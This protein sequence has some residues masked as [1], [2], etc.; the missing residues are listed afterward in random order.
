MKKVWSY[1]VQYC[2]RNAL[3]QLMESYQMLDSPE[4]IETSKGVKELIKFLE[5]ENTGGLPVV[6]RWW[7]KFPYVEPTPE[8]GEE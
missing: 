6:I 5:T 7:K 3:G 2:W 8:A 4:D 1:Y